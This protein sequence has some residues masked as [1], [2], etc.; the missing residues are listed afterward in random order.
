[1]CG[2]YSVLHI[3]ITM[4]CILRYTIQGENEDNNLVYASI[5][6]ME[7]LLTTALKIQEKSE[8]LGNYYNKK[9]EGITR[10]L[11][12]LDTPTANRGINVLNPIFL[13]KSMLVINRVLE[14]Q[15]HYL[16][17]V[18]NINDDLSRLSL[19]KDSKNRLDVEMH[20][21]TFLELQDFY[22]L[23]TQQAANGILKNSSIKISLSALD[24]Y[25]IGSWALENRDAYHAKLWLNEAKR[26][27][28][29]N[30]ADKTIPLERILLKLANV[31]AVYKDDEA[32]NQLIDEILKSDPDNEAAQQ[33]KIILQGSGS[34]F[35]KYADSYR[36]IPMRHNLGGNS[37]ATQ[38][39]QLC[40]Q[41]QTFIEQPNT[42]CYYEH[43][44]TY[45]SVKVEVLNTKPAFA[46]L[47]EVITNGEIFALNQQ[48]A[49]QRQTRLGTN[50]STLINFKANK[51]IEGF[52]MRMDLLAI[53][54]KL[55]DDFLYTSFDIGEYNKLKGKPL[56]YHKGFLS[57]YDDGE[58]FL[59]MIFLNNVE[60]GGH[61]IFPSL[62]ISVA[63]RKGDA[64]LWSFKPGRENKYLIHTVCPVYIGNCTVIYI[65]GY[66][67]EYY[68]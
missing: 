22:D 50:H 65:R 23:D 27:L 4:L 45:Y 19:E 2:T 52:K 34:I 35:N 43:I 12:E 32:A 16:K 14:K 54:S 42:F 51:I 58:G 61:V 1:M 67:Q 68:N 66:A 8:R 24:C 15:K 62:N 46:A 29:S 47:H 64:L 60:G 57:S 30:S 10:A 49:Y 21:R 39:Q 20:I 53:P 26:R 37:N 36:T 63:P 3:L 7:K 40:Q 25:E 48:A 17:Q 41:S 44:Y 56:K 33:F 6:D 38:V 18:E 28:I 55:M 13:I 11:E 5:A 31:Y 9:L 59:L